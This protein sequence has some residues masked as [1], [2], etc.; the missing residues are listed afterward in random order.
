MPQS[1]NI[2]WELP[3][4][5]ANVVLS[6][7]GKQPFETV[8]D[9]IMELRNQAGRQLQALQQPGPMNGEDRLRQ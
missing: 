3:I 5:Q 7:L 4:E 2:T 8:A 9:L 1:P 6:I